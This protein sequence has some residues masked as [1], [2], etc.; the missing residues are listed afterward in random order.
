VSVSSNVSCNQPAAIVA[1]GATT[2]CS[3][4]LHV[5][6]GYGSSDL[7]FCVANCSTIF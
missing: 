7:R 5:L 1:M 6:G 2:Y 3:F 4:Q